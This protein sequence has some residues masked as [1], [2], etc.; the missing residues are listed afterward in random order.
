M[1]TSKLIIS[2]ALM[3]LII[4]G[5]RF[6]P[7]VVF[8]NGK[9]PPDIIMY[10]GKYLPPAIIVAITVYCFKDTKFYEF[11]FGAKEIISALTVVAL[12][13]RL[14]NT[15]ISITI[16]TVLYMLLLRL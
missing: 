10:L 12:Q 11:P 7:F 13:L 6:F 2:I 9:K 14:K 15:M 8:G 1:N 5:T 4:A 3:S 16:G